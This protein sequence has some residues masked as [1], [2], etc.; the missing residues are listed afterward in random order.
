[1]LLHTARPI[2]CLI[3]QKPLMPRRVIYD[4][5]NLAGICTMAQLALLV[6]L[7]L[8]SSAA[9]SGQTSTVTSRCA[10]LLHTLLHAMADE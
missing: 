9:V 5:S 3:M 4:R 8:A 2:L 10:G 6:A 1:M 7:L